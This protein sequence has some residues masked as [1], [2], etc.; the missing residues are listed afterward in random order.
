MSAA[1]I[2]LFVYN[3]PE[4]TRQTVEALQRNSASANSDL[5]VYSDAPKNVAANA[6]VQLVREYV[7]QISGFKSVYIIERPDNFGLAKS[8]IDGVTQLCDQYGCVIVLED[9][10]A[11]SPHFID[12]MNAGLDRYQDEDRVM[13]VAGYMFTGPLQV[14]EDALLLPF[15]SSWGWATW[16]RAWKHFDPQA[17]GYERL[18]ADKVLQRKF[19]LDGHYNYFKMLSRQQRGEVDSWA[20]RWYL[21]VFLRQGLALYP[22]KTLVHNLGF[23]GSGVNCAVSDFAQDN[24]E[25]QFRVNSLP[26]RIDISDSAEQVFNNM[27]VSKLSWSSICS[28]LVGALQ[29]GIAGWRVVR[30]T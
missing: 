5:F 11:T 21:S 25:T 4:H 3:R 13:Q 26:Q 10:L 16:Q 12:Y 2:A 28:R 17:A 27:P 14:E 1:P 22:R 29:S 7:A 6:G 20:V 30:H 18:K 8:I 9:D 23:D 15:I 24:V 19:N